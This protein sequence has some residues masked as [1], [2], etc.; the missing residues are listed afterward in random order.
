[1]IVK[2]RRSLEVIEA[3]G[4]IKELLFLTALN[5]AE[6]MRTIREEKRRCKLKQ[7]ERTKKALNFGHTQML[8]VVRMSPTFLATVFEL[9]KHAVDG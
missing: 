9:F 1:M 8:G 4:S 7:Q 2:H 6:H 5:L 3:I